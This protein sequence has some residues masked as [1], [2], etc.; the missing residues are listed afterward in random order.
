MLLINLDADTRIEVSV[1]TENP[2]GNA[3]SIISS[4]KKRE[5]YHLKAKDGDLHS[6]TVL[7]ND[8]VLT[9][10]SSGKIPS[11][12]PQRV[13]MSDPIRVDPFSIVF[14]HI[15]SLKIPACT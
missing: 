1:S 5:E 8:K 12:K 6:Q 11:M 13:D 2:T 10:S 7:L 15:P 9:V 14:S 3:K 4:G